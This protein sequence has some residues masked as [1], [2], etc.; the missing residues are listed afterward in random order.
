M[1]TA[2]AF[3]LQPRW[4][5]KNCTSLELFKLIKIYHYFDTKRNNDNNNEKKLMKI[6]FIIIFNKAR[7]DISSD[8]PVREFVLYDQKGLKR[9]LSISILLGILIFPN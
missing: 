8:R 9:A 7:S 4:C 6:T 1:C 3:K 2:Y 5:G